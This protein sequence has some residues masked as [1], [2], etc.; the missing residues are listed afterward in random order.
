MMVIQ[1]PISVLISTGTEGIKEGKSQ[2]IEEK[3]AQSSTIHAYHPYL[4]FP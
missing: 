2:S 3:Y 1:E 4:P